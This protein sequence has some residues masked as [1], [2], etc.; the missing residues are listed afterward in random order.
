MMIKNVTRYLLVVI[1]L[2]CQGAIAAGDEVP[3]LDV[4]QTC[5]AEASADPSETAGSACIED[6]QKARDQLIND[7]DRFAS[8]DRSSC[9]AEATSIAGIAS[10]VELLTC[11]QVARDARKL[12][13]E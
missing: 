9:T 2:G 4:A 3:R 12:S 8:T 13:N 10:Y 1:I 5:H 11:L 6:Q 7:W